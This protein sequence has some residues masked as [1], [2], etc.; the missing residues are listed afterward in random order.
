M[1]SPSPCV[2]A[3][4]ATALVPDAAVSPTPRSQTRAVTSPRR[5]TRATCTFVRSGKRG[6]ASSRGPSSPIWLGSPLTT[7]CGIADRDRD[8]LDRRRRAPAARPPPGPAPTRRD[9][10]RFAAPPRVRGPTCT[11]ASAEPVRLISQAA[12]MRVPLPDISACDPSGLTMPIV[13]SSPSTDSTST[14]PSVPDRSRSDAEPSWT[15]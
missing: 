5:S 6:C 9:R 13:T 4:T 14:A 1:T 2:A 10:P 11:R 8:Q 12:A 7:A 3:A 15:R